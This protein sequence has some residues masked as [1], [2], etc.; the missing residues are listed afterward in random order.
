R[1]KSVYA[2]PAAQDRAVAS[3]LSS[4]SGQ[5]ELVKLDANPGAVKRGNLIRVPTD[6]VDVRVVKARGKERR[7]E[8][9]GACC[10]RSWA[11]CRR[12]PSRGRA[13]SRPGISSQ[14][15]RPWLP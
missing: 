10:H 12:V 3:G 15:W 14:G 13:P 7:D 1:T 9:G 8:G 4:A 2:N 11:R 5:A 6:D